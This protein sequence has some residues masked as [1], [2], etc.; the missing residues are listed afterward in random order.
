M[1]SKTRKKDNPLILPLALI[2]AIAVLFSVYKM[3]D[4]QNQAATAD[5]ADTAAEVIMILERDVSE[6]RALRY[7]YNGETNSF[8]W[9]GTTGAWEYDKDKAF[10][11][12]QDTV[13]TMAAAISSIGVYRTLD[14]GDTGAY[15]FDTPAAEI[16]VT[17]AD[18]AVHSFAIGDLN[19]MSGYR[20]L[21]DTESGTVYTIAP[22]L[23]PYFQ[24]T[25]ADLFTYDT[26]P[27]DIEATYIESVTL[28]R[29]G[30]EKVASDSEITQNI[31]TKFQLLKP[32]EYADYSGTDEAMEQ[33]GIGES[34]LKIAY[35]RAVTVT[36]TSGSENTTRIAASCTVRFGT[37][38]EEGK[39]PYV[40]DGS[41]V[42]YL[43]DAA[44]L[45]AIEDCFDEAQ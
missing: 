8:T 11:L 41:D 5:T 39:L 6:V 23:L 24:V 40:I 43:T 33:Y 27:T 3:M 34:S 44:D 38:T 16:S 31:Y 29:A 28:N 1:A 15:G 17:F 18:G 30:E 25:L 2:A 7:T 12:M 21:K 13:S 9:N 10:P 45:D 32:M 36:D 37:V 14:T 22:A 35:K 42:I 4:T 19:S 20:Y 26:L